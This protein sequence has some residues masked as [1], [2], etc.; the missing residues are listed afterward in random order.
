MQVE[1]VEID[2]VEIADQADVRHEHPDFAVAPGTF[3]TAIKKQAGQRFKGG[4]RP[5][6]LAPPPSEI[7]FRLSVPAEARLELAAGIDLGFHDV[8]IRVRFEAEMDGRTVFEQVLA[9]TERPGD[10]D[11]VEASVNL[12][13]FAGREARLVLRTVAEVPDDDGRPIRCGWGTPRITTTREIPRS[14]PGPR[15]PNLLYVVV[16]TLRADHVGCYGYERPTTPSLDRLAAEGL[17]FEQPVSPSPWTWPSTASLLS[18]L[19]PYTH[20][21]LMSDRCYFPSAAVTLAEALRDARFTT[22]AIS[23]NPLVCTAQNFDQGFEEFDE[24]FHADAREVTD[25]FLAWLDRSREFRFFAYLHY[26]DP[27]LPYRPPTLDPVEE[28]R[29]RPFEEGERTRYEALSRTQTITDL[30]DRPEERGAIRDLYDGEIRFWDAQFGRLLDGLER[31]GLAD[32]TVIVVTSDHGEEIYD[33]GRVGHARTLYDELVMVPLVVHDPS[34]SGARRIP[35]QVETV[36]VPAALLERFGIAAPPAMVRGGLPLRAEPGFEGVVGFSTTERWEDP[37]EAFLRNQ[38]SIRDEAWKLI[39]SEDG[40]TRLF[41]LREDPGET[42][43]VAGEHPD[44]TAAMGRRLREWIQTT[45]DASL[46]GERVEILS[47]EMLEQLR[48]L[49]YVATDAAG[50]PEEVD[51]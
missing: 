3:Q 29:G 49:G 27:H 50:D 6:I 46:K 30:W 34:A 36:R 38:N 12:A 51:R 31:L 14:E 32:R 22:Y 43:D 18:G 42:R 41:S 8:P 40:R 33:H 2:L 19:Y 4:E 28:V 1:V 37:R 47:D 21:V 44:R 20:G 24:A 23:A 11:W 25:R 45:K 7:A 39:E 15:R 48:K 10:R 35:E 9:P 13:P 17:V 5:A 26:F 16:D